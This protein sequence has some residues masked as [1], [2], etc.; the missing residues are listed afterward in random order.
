MTFYDS[1]A[2]DGDVITVQSA[3][4]S[5]TVRLA[6]APITIALPAPPD[7]LVKIVGTVDGAGGGVTL[8]TVTPAGP[9]PLAVLSVGQTISIP[10]AA[11]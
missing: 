4:F 3:G 6:K 11:E 9:I 8:G 5:Q 2:E 7:G 10:V 1:D